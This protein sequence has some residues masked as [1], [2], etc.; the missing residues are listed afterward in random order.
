MYCNQLKQTV[1]NKVIVVTN[2]GSVSAVIVEEEIEL[3]IVDYDIEG[4]EKFEL[5]TMPKIWNRE[6]VKAYI[7][8]ANVQEVR[9]D[10]VQKYF[11]AI[12]GDVEVPSEY[13]QSVSEFFTKNG[14]NSQQDLFDFIMKKFNIS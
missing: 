7:Y 11:K 6:S 12:K 10:V 2:G 3:Q 13:I 1:M 8:K 4:A 14:I 5:K 9:P